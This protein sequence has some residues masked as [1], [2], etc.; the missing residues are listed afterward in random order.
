MVLFREFL[1]YLFGNF[2][3]LVRGIILVLFRDFFFVSSRQVWVSFKEIYWS[4]L[5]NFTGLV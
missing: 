1:G 5:R 3:G 2:T 4:A